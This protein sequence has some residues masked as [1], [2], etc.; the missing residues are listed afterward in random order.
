[1]Y[2]FLIMSVLR[3]HFTQKKGCFLSAIAQI[4]SPILERKL[5]LQEVYSCFYVLFFFTTHVI[6]DWLT[7]AIL[8][9]CPKALT[10]P[11]I[12]E[13]PSSLLLHIFFSSYLAQKFKRSKIGKKKLT[14]NAFFWDF[15][16]MRGAFV[17]NQI[18]FKHDSA[19]S[20]FK[21][22]NFGFTLVWHLTKPVK[23]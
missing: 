20:S 19:C 15:T 10:L 14:Q 16:L 5:F 18:K 21:S 9:D 22:E 3:E 1:M 12:N 6:T 17:L 13:G 2:T 7:L 8:A 11:S 23:A 4:T